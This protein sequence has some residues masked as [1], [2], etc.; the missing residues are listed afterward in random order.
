MS[1][2]KLLTH[3]C[4]IYHLKTKFNDDSGFGIPAEDR[5]EEYY[6]EE[7]PDVKATKCYFVSKSQSIVQGEPNAEVVEAWL[8]HFLL[9][10][11]I[12]TNSKVIWDG[13]AY[14]TQKPRKIRNHH[15]EVVLI[16]R[17]NL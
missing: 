11:D 7:V 5:Q 12:R 2:E 13:V 8:V 10:E 9:T 3:E 6:Y 14:K 4:D 15:Q 16:R 17:D 1:Y